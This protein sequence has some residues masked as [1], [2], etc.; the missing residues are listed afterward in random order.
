MDRLFRGSGL[1]REKWDTQ[2]GERTYGGKTIAKALEGFSATTDLSLGDD[3]NAMR[4]LA[5]HAEAL[6]FVPEWK[7]FFHYDG[8]RFLC[9]KGDVMELAKQTGRSIY[10]EAGN[11]TDN[12]RRNALAKHAKGSDKL[13]RLRAMMILAS[14]DPRI[15]REVADFDANPWL[16]NCLNGTVNLQTGELQP[17]RREDLITKIIHLD[18]D[19][20]AICPLWDEFLDRIFRGEDGKPRTKLIQYMQRSLGSCLTGIT[21]DQ[22]VFFW[23]GVGGNGKSVLLE[24]FRGILGE[25]AKAATYATFTSKP[26]DRTLNDLARLVGSR[27]VSAS[28]NDEGSRLSEAL[29]KRLSGNDTV[30]ARFLYKGI[31]EYVPTF[32]TILVGNHRP[33]IKGTDHAIWRRIHLVP[34][35]QVIPDEEQDHNLLEK[36]KAEYQGILAW[37]VQGCMEWQT[38][39]LGL[40]DE[41]KDA[42]ASYKQEMD[43]VGNFLADCCVRGDYATVKSSALYHAYEKWCGDNGEQARSHVKFSLQLEERNLRKKREIT[44]Q[45]WQGLGLICKGDNEQ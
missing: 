25:Y 2:H 12:E 27:M 11:E 41:V 9:D 35:D 28:E 29:I 44:G 7:N 31:F 34:F 19:H 45:F 30:T 18:Y 42:T 22:R 3:G 15:R 21:T 8:Q 40:P 20:D 17:H 37:M 36:L 24:T 43:T 5:Q 10:C 32:K 13:E 14:T 23:L 33:T 6:A 26:D 39:G 38:Q 1:F 16:L 4:F